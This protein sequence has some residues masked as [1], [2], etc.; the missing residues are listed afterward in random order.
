MPRFARLAALLLLVSMAGSAAAD[1]DV[2]LECHAD[3]DITRE[4]SN[5]PGTSVYVD[6]SRLAA[7]VHEGIE[8]VECHP[9]ASP[10]HEERLAPAAC[11]T[12]HDDVEAIY[13]TSLH[14]VA[15]ARGEADAP[16]CGDCHGAHDIR[17]ADDPGSPVARQQIPSTCS[18]CHA[19][20][21]FIQRRP[22]GLASPLKGYEKSVHFAAL[23]RDGSGATCTDCHE[24]HDLRKPSDPAS[25]IHQD[26]I[27]GTCGQCHGAVREVYEKSIHGQAVRFGVTDAPTCVDCHAEHEIRSPDDPLSRVY[28]TAIVN[29][30]C[31]Q[32]HENVKIT[33]RYGL[34]AGRFKSYRDTYHGLAIEDG[35]VL[36]ANC[37]SCHGVHNILPSTDPASTINPA[38]LQ[39]TCGHC[40]PS[41]GERFADIP[42][43]EG[44]GT[45]GGGSRLGGLVRDFYIGL[46]AAT[47]LAMVFHNGAIFAH[48]LRQ[49][50]RRTRSGTTY[51]RFT[52]FQV[53][54]HVVLVLSFATL[55]VTGF[56]LKFPDVW[57]TGW[58]SALGLEEAV[59]RVVHRVA[60]VVMVIQSAVYLVYLLV[61]R[62]GRYELVSLMPRLQDVRDVVLNL[63]YHLGRAHSKPAFGRYGYIEKV[64]FWALVWGVAVMG[65]TG[66]VLWAPE[67]ATRLFPGWAFTV[68]ELVHY[69]E[70]W[71]AT[72]AIL[73]WHIFFVVLHPS[74][75]PLNMTCLD[76]KISEDELIAHHPLEHPESDASAAP[77]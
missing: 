28:P 13:N 4:G 18:T 75:Y 56:A 26:R 54:Q 48:A 25:S 11:A 61:T 52:T 21:E 50:Y 20:L 59:R 6:A 31:I 39:E 38:R 43:H 69:Y 9:D 55:V 19:D 14:G 36:T 3:R 5:R 64:E 8:C 34:E 40:H 2:C 77:S 65:A 1:N 42:V 53:I 44:S 60:G 17:Y 68:S 73:I 51:Q 57:W 49:K 29:S 67:W 7:S 12:C 23:Q 27:P 71:L 33:S 45:S 76:G 24:A 72:L 62:H 63:R 15:L 66:L 32:C 70:A 22:V 47:V 16:I 35:T 37:A 58:L 74:E 10:D 46:I 30:T 41:A